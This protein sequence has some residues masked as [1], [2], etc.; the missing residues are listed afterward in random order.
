MLKHLM[1]E[2]A[3]V[4]DRLVLIPAIL[5]VVLV[6]LYALLR[7]VLAAPSAGRRDGV[8]RACRAGFG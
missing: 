2:T 4:R 3:A 1:Y 8:V 7:A 5:I 6:V